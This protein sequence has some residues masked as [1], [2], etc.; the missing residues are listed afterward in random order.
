MEIF[1]KDARSEITEEYYSLVNKLGIKNYKNK[2]WR[3]CR[4][5]W[6]K[7]VPKQGQA[8]SVQGEL[9][10]EIEKLR[11]EAQCN[12]NLNWDENFEYFCDNISYI[13]KSSNLFNGKE[14]NNI[15]EIMHFIKE[16]GKYAYAYYI[17][18]KISD[19]EYNP[20]KQAYVDNDIYDYICEK[21]ALFSTQNPKIIPYEKKDFIYR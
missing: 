8:D 5:I 6:K 3:E 13:L 17:E 15:E 16:N 10:R 4:K 21:I 7:Y 19:S 11:I 20:I 1:N 12:G 2:H 18:E 9:L 14:C